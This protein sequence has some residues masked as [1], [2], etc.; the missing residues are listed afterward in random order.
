MKKYPPEIDFERSLEKMGSFLEKHLRK[1]KKDRFVVGLSGGVDS[2]VVAAVVCETVGSEKLVAVKMPYKT[3]NPQ[4][5]KDADLVIEKYK[6]KNYRIDISNVVDAYFESEF[7]LED[8]NSPF[9]KLRKGNFAAR[10]R[11]AVLFDISAKENAL[12][13]GTG[14]RSEI[15]LGYT[16]W[17]GDSASSLNPIG[18]IYKTQV[19]QLAKF[20]KI[21]ETITSKPPSADLWANQ[22]DEGDMGIKYKDA[23]AVLYLIFD[24]KKTEK[25]TSKILNISSSKVTKILERVKKNEFKRKLPPIAKIF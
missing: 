17:Y 18:N 10:A 23:D 12:V 2:A 1:A 14:N 19:Y 4:S 9:F 16:T 13:L 15:L 20:L 11:M 3:S 24:L 5:E 25:E 21:P 8:K 7:M 22:T 6:L